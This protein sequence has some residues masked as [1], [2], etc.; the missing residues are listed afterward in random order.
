M[1]SSKTNHLFWRNF[2]K[3]LCIIWIHTLQQH[4]FYTLITRKKDDRIIAF[5]FRSL[6][7]TSKMFLLKGV[8][9]Q[10]DQGRSKITKYIILWTKSLC[11]TDTAS[12]SQ[13]IKTII[14]IKLSTRWA[15]LVDYTLYHT[16]TFVH[17]IGWNFAL[18]CIDKKLC[19]LK[20]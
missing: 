19:F 7:S 1:I 2:A 8:C 10:I 3:I 13:A 12:V 5:Y 6:W 17:S 20:N 14:S 15:F 11:S 16:I 18:C 4:S 9:I